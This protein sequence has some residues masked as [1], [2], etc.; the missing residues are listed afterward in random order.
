MPT[1]L[2]EIQAKCSTEL[3]ATRDCAAI[4][5]AFNAGRKRIEQPHFVGDGTVSNALGRPTGPLFVLWLQRAASAAAAP[6]PD[7]P[8]EVQAAYAEIAQACRLLLEGKLDLG[9]PIVRTG[10]DGLVGVAPGFTQE[11]ANTIKALAEVPDPI[12]ENEVVRACWSNAGQW[13]AG[14]A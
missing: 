2:E 11:Q 12:D 3:L 6:A 9:L 10:I 13:L 14:G 7:A 4:T 8:I 5:A 1:L